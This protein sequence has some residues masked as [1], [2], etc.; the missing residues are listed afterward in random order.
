MQ[1]K[2]VVI[3]GGGVGGLSAA[4]RLAARGLKPL[5]LEKRPQIGGKLN[6]LSLPHPLRPSDRPFQF[7]T[8]PSLLTL[9][10]IFQDLFAAAGRDVR[11]Y[12]TIQPLEPISKFVWEDGQ[13]LALSSNTAQLEQSL[14]QFASADLPGF[15]AL[16][17]RGKQIWD[18]A[19]EF[20]LSHA[21]EQIAKMPGSTPLDGL[22]MA[23]I[24]FRIGMF[25]R[26]S[27][28][29]D[30]HVSNPRLRE[31]L[32]QYATYSGASPF[33][34]PATLAVIPFCELHF[35]GWYIQG[36]MY[37]LALALE[38]LA[39]ELGVEIRTDTTVARIETSGN[40]SAR[41]VTGVITQ[42]GGQI[43]CDVALC[44]ADVVWAYQHLLTPEDRPHF[45]DR[46]L[47]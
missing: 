41:R 12:L 29:I 43:P 5:L 39:R 45:P 42:T 20:F 30:R 6:R 17:G 47:A 13:S 23:S 9:P 10:F 4:I 7:D 14:V 38:R 28:L 22:R 25:S 24:P 35:G 33:L 44:N 1:D 21:P 3:I 34:A 18:L 15:R 26:F 31:V 11:D 46:K 32:Y 19:G 2:R 16:L 27:K 40:D 8:G 37:A 36:G